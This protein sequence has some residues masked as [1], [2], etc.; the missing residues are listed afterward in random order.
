MQRVHE[1]TWPSSS[2]YR[3]VCSD[4]L[5]VRRATVLLGQEVCAGEELAWGTAGT[6]G[7]VRAV[8]VGDVIVANVAE[9]GTEVSKPI[10][11][12][13]LGGVIDVPVHV[14]GIREEANTER[15][16]WRITP[17]FVEETTGTIQVLEVG[18]ILLATEEVHI[19]DLKVGPEVAGGVSAAT[20]GVLGARLII[21]DPLPHVVLAQ[22]RRVR[23]QELAGLGPKGLDGLRGVVKVDGEAVG[24]VSVL[25]VAEYVVVNIA[26]EL[27]LG[28]DAPIV[29]VLLE[30]GVLVEHAAV[31]PA[32]LMIGDLRSVL[33]VFLLK[34]LG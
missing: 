30:R 34:N 33:D 32:H 7:G 6:L 14:V 9:P 31:P 18:L 27:N 10:L 26:E 12:C 5:E 17:A 3:S 28:L 21:R 2:V 19:A 4:V 11:E 8:V 15:V 20:L 1:A 13:M 23:S 24:L 16:D 25:H 29:T 22:I